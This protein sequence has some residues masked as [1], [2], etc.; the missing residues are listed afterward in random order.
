MTTGGQ[1]V[2]KER[3][4]QPQ[5]RIYTI[6]CTNPDAGHAYS[7]LNLWSRSRMNFSI[8]GFIFAGDTT[9]FSM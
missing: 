5:A 9:S 2:I 6:L 4:Y 1:S 7:T 3:F 8:A